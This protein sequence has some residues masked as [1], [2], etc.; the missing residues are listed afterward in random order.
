M[1]SVDKHLR[2]FKSLDNLRYINAKDGSHASCQCKAA[3][4]PSLGIV[5]FLSTVA[6][7]LYT[8]TPTPG[9]V[10]GHTSEGTFLEHTL[11]ID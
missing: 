6:P 2:K 9:R 11:R 3:T 1:F 7:L 5:G 4:L 8:L 10:P